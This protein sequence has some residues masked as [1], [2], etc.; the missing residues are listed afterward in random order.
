M[1]SEG[2]NRT[3]ELMSSLARQT[4]VCGP[5]C[6]K[7]YSSWPCKNCFWGFFFMQV[8]V[9]FYTR[10]WRYLFFKKKTLKNVP[11]TD[12][13][14]F[15]VFFAFH[16][17]C[18][19]TLRLLSMS[20]PTSH[21][22][23]PSPYLVSSRFQSLPS[24][25]L[26]FPIAHHPTPRSVCCLCF[27]SQTPTS[28]TIAFLFLCAFLLPR[29]RTFPRAWADTLATSFHLCIRRGVSSALFWKAAGGVGWVRSL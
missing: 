1:G 29:R 28:L 23:A 9:H 13:E 19:K 5:K 6:L 26:S 20:L 11:K 22:R 10:G 24:G 4:T 15:F 21:R 17:K 2:K 25:R 27:I 16:P 8:S 7:L 14:C 12:N 3:K 18:F